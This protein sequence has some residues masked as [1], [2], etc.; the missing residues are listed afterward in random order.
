MLTPLTLLLPVKATRPVLL[1]RPANTPTMPDRLTTGLPEMPFP[2][3]TA[4]PGPEETISRGTTVPRLFLATK[5]L[6]ASF[7]LLAAPVRPMVNGSSEPP[8][9]MLRSPVTAKARL[10]GS[11]GS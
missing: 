9:V 11:E 10:F 2:L 3:V 8:S 7:R 6:P 4:M 5:P 1:P